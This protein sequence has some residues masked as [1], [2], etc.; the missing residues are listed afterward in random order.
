[1]ADLRKKFSKIFDQYID[2]IYRFVYLK[3]NSEDTAQ[4]LT[5]ETFL[6]CWERYQKN[7]EIDNIQAFLY[8]IARNLVVD[9]YREKG[10]AAFV[11]IEDYPVIDPTQD[12]E[13]KVH[14][15]SD[16]AQV[17]AVLAN[18]KEDYQNVII[19]H[20]LD[21]MSIRE[22]S[23]MIGRTEESTRVL[24]YRALNALREKLNQTA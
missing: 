14:L 18:L 5:S 12:L 7:Q 2:K 23:Q 19:W 24:L 10:K 17:K 13:A 20:Y 8:Q 21:D 4:D 11:S 6:R 9:F 15:G 3:V 16:M 1:M 22:V